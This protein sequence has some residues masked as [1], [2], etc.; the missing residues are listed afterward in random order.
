MRCRGSVLIRW[1]F[2]NRYIL[3]A[4]AVGVGFVFLLWWLLN[5]PMPRV[6][7]ERSLRI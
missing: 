6:I 2:A 1:L 5:E 7:P 4:S 3:I